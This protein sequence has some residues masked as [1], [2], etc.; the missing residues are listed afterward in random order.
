MIW[1]NNFTGS[2][3]N[4]KDKHWKGHFFRLIELQD[5]SSLM[6]MISKIRLNHFMFDVLAIK[7]LIVNIQRKGG[8][9]RV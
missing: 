4:H 2:Y 7:K 3:A 1:R 6:V 8:E 5:E 9:V